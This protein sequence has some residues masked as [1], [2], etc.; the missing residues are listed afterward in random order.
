MTGWNHVS[1]N[2]QAW[3]I[4]GWVNL[5]PFRQTV[6]VYTNFILNDLST[7]LRN[8]T[9]WDSL[10]CE[11]ILLWS[12]VKWISCI[13]SQFKVDRTVLV[14]TQPRSIYHIVRHSKLWLYVLLIW[15]I[16]ANSEIVARQSIFCHMLHLTPLH[17]YLSYKPI[18]T[19]VLNQFI[20]YQNNTTH[21]EV[22][23]A[24]I[25]ADGHFS[26]AYS[27]ACPQ[28]VGIHSKDDSTV[29]TKHTVSN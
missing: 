14:K 20:L 19:I 11:C 18:T 17:R 29:V 25:T 7:P 15:S 8:D 16:S 12:D 1:E 6:K 3:I 13:Q 28:G 4:G 24:F 22:S 27:N 10:I 9:F 2:T 23:T 5:Y 26:L 21:L